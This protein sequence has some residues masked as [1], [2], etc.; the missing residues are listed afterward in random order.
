[1]LLSINPLKSKLIALIYRY[2]R[3]PLILFKIIIIII[4]KCRI[5]LNV[6]DKIYS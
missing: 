6:L 5:A 1:M 2:K 4:K 3:L